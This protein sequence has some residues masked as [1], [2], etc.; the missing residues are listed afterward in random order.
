MRAV[1]V[2][3]GK[4]PIENLYI[5]EAP[6]PVAG[7]HEILVKVKAFGLNRMDILQ[8]N[9]VYPLPPGAPTIL[10]VE[11]SGTIASLGEDVSSDWK[12]GDEVFGI[13]SGGAYAEY[14]VAVESHLLRKPSSLSYVDAASLLEVFLTAYQGIHYYGRIQPG[15]NVLVHAAASGVGIAAIQMARASGAKNVIATASS[16]SKLDWLKSITNGAT[17]GVNYKEQD[18]AAEVATITEG[19]GVD[20]VIDFVGTTHWEK[21][22]QSLAVDGRM[23]IFAFLSGRIVPQFDIGPILG[24]RLTITGS[25]LRA[26]SKEYQAELIKC[27]KR[28][29]LGRVSGQDGNGEIK[30]Y[31]HQVFDWKD[32]QEAHRVMEANTNIGKLIVEVV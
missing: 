31:V 7:L 2:K 4:G 30:T 16:T 15:D 10:G 23:V 28:D 21:N 32:I 8:R 6:T 1:L 3:D 5:G 19:K 25:M 29:Y 24:K 20:I 27:A 11:F 22:I 9:G 18:F 12:V 26:R 13:A 14:I 17:H